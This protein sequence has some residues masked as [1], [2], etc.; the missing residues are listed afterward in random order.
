MY[1]KNKK[2]CESESEYPKISV[3]LKKLKKV[4]WQSSILGGRS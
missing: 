2:K 3:W 1:K 4:A